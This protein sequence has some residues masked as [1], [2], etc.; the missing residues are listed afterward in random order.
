MT[1]ASQPA[2]TRSTS[3]KPNKRWTI[4]SAI[5]TSRT[6]SGIL[7]PAG[8]RPLQ[9]RHR[10]EDARPQETEQHLTRLMEF[11][12]GHECDHVTPGLTASYERW[13]THIGKP[14]LGE[15]P[16]VRQPVSAASV[17]RELETL[18]AC[19]THAWKCRRRERS[20]CHATAKGRTT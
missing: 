4:I 17:R 9:A 5:V 10:S 11:F 1:N 3:R 14:S 15:P 8:H 12:R 16:R 13:R 18:R 6:R 19:L 20:P 2:S 7:R